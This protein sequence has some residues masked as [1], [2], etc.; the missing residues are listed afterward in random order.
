MRPTIHTIYTLAF[1]AILAA[2]ASESGSK[3]CPTTGIVCPEDTI[4]AAAQPVCLVSSCGNGQIDP[5]EQCDDGNI[6]DGDRCSSL[7]RNEICG[8]GVVDGSAGETCDDN[9]A[10][11]GDGC[12]EIC[13]IEVCG[14][15]RRD[16]GEEC[17]DGNLDNGD[18]CTGTPITIDDGAGGTRSSPQPCS[19][20]EVC[21]NGIVDFQVGE[22][23]D[24][25]N[26]TSGDG[27]NSDCRS[28]EG[29]GNGILD[30]G[31]ECDDGNTNNNDRCLFNTP[32]GQC[33]LSQCG[34]GVIESATIPGVPARE[35]C[36]PGDPADPFPVETVDCNIDCTLSTCGDRRINTTDGEEC[37][38]GSGQNLDANNCTSECKVNF[39]GDGKKDEQ[40][41]NTEACD[42]GNTN[43]FDGC[44]NACQIATCGNSTIDTGEQCD[45]G[46]TSNNDLCVSCKNAKCGDGFVQ[47]GVEECDGDGNGVGDAIAGDG[48]FN[49][50]V[51]R[52]GNSIVDF[53]ETCDDG[54]DPV[55]DPPGGPTAPENTDACINSLVTNCQNARCGDGYL[56]D[57][58]D[59]DDGNNT[60]GDGCSA[61]CLNEGCGNGILETVRGEQC[62][63]HNTMGGDGCSSTCQLEDCGD[64]VIN[65]GEE[66][67]GT[68]TMT[69]PGVGGET[70]MCNA[71]CTMRR[72]G[73]GKINNT[74][75]E[76]CDDGTIAGV[77]QNQ[78]NRDCRADCRLNF[79]TDGF[80]N[81]M[82]TP[83][84]R[85]V[86]DDGNQVNNDTCSNSC[87]LASCGNGLL[88]TSEECDLGMGPN[89]NSDTGPCTLGC[90]INVCGD[91]KIRTGVEECDP[92][93]IGLTVDGPCLP[94][95]RYARCGDG[96][97][98]SASVPPS[99]SNPFAEACDNG[100]QNGATACQYGAESC[101]LCTTACQ[102]TAGTITR[103]GD[104]AVNGPAGEEQCDK[105]ETN[106]DPR[107]RNGYTECI[108]NQAALDCTLCSSSCQNLPDRVHTCGDGV[109]DNGQSWGGTEACDLGT[110]PNGNGM[111][112]PCPYGQTCAR[113]S[114]NCGTA[115]TVV[116]PHCGD[117]TVNGIEE[118]DNDTDPPTGG[119]G[120]SA[121]CTIETGFVCP[122]NVCSSPCG[123]GIKA[124]DET[125]DDGNTNNNDG[126]NSACTM[127]DAGFTCMLVGSITRCAPVCGD[128]KRVLGEAC[129]D[130]GTANNDGCS[131]TCTVEFGYSCTGGSPTTA[132]ACASTC[133]DGKKAAGA[134]AEGCDDGGTGVGDGCNGSCDVET[135]WNCTG[136]QPSVCVRQQVCGDGVLVLPEKCDDNDNTVPP[137]SGDG[138]SSTCTVE[139][140][141]TCAT[142]GA[143]CTKTCGDGVIA[144]GAEACDDGNNVS[145][146]G[147]AMGC[148]ATEAGFT[149]VTN[150]NRTVCT[151]IC[152]DGKRVQGEAC[153]DGNTNS[154]DGCHG[155]CLV[156]EFGFSCTGGTPTTPDTCNSPCGDGLRAS[157]EA[158]DD[159][160]TMSGD[161]CS[162]TCTIEP[163]YTCNTATPN[164][165]G[166]QCGD[167][168][169]MSPE[170]CD[171]NNTMAADGCSATCVEEQ[172]YD[173]TGT[174]STCMSTCGD[175]VRAVGDEACDDGGTA[176][177]D[178][179][180]ATCT[181]EVGFACTE[182]GA[183]L[184]S[185][186][187]NNDNSCAPDEY[188]MTTCQPA[189][190]DGSTCSRDEMCLSDNCMGTTCAP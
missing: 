67:D 74:A 20:T 38:A 100:E 30:P 78:N 150:N 189:L 21:G 147:C 83:A 5:G 143:A 124:S 61:L 71:D 137:S 75:M 102:L 87:Q 90:K 94:T 173:C 99:N 34:D 161:G 54:Q 47:A 190:V 166:P 145:G 11:G 86:C 115:S 182:N 118:C 185:C 93:T 141:W 33:K 125:C 184:S 104:G 1:A 175:G 44:S 95:C 26:T 136:S 12:S 37:D 114:A 186:T 157:D 40:L 116:G 105:G 168:L 177:G 96:D 49:C 80:Q 76:Q 6:I 17:D 69:T 165:C 130:G 18:G 98:Q 46:N 92:G 158:C 10:T 188:C 36:D 58:E 22:V 172:G 160:D 135:G 113:C 164:V 91:G 32:R 162:S 7:C 149:C 155:S 152:G 132:D 8:N 53:G 112:P 16:M 35:Q 70:A 79:C 148:A 134:D 55:I 25:N 28:G 89:G 39:C 45:D 159:M 42:D 43:N 101:Q 23:C 27:C 179:C 9:N 88:D 97:Q 133:G 163:H 174:P 64:G 127:T 181:E 131:S 144:A 24:D 111:S 117:G 106:A 122:G 57:T 31:E 180:S 66:C 65:V 110:G 72:C 3:I 81:T 2:C 85:E 187:C 59:C 41:P 139:T 146:D 121:Q 29:C 13:T 138:C 4:C 128:G 51:E 14:N 68:G 107:L 126:C 77:N 129:D 73:D 178:G 50:H 176:P 170:T 151:P 142:P 119:D 82:G 48:C 120:C 154:N 84:K 63:D 171:D 15:G 156:V 19:S 183:G 109:V 56:R 123:D 169:I 140:G 108:Y 167:G 103:C 60:D 52:C 153:D 62:D